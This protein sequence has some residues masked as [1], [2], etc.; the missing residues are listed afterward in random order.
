MDVQNTREPQYKRCLDLAENRRTTL[1]LMSNQV[2]HDDPK[3]LGFV[4]ARYK[5]VAKM[6][7]GKREVLEIGCADAFASRI[8]RQEVERLV[9][10]DFD[11]VFIADVNAR[12]DHAWPIE[13]RVHD[14]I[15]NPMTVKF[16]AAY[17]VDVLEHINPADESKF[18]GNLT[19]S[20]HENSVCIMGTPSLESQIYASEGSKA[21]HVNC[22]TSEQLRDTMANYFKN[23][24]MFGMNDEV[25]HVG[26]PRMCHYLFAVACGVR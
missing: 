10:S 22:K 9:V 24:F 11:P 5:F 6:L 8:V 19:Q 18:F 7:V 1:G 23:V 26:Y 13:A 12:L 17:S 21:G 2:W 3:R 14:F 16:D 4:F 20:L 15:E 25:L